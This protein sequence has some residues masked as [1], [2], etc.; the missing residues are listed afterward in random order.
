M[1][2]RDG[3]VSNSSSSSFL[4]CKKD[5]TDTQI[6]KINNHMEE[7]EKLGMYVNIH[8]EWAIHDHGDALKLSTGMDNFDMVTFLNRIGVR[9]VIEWSEF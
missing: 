4:I 3:F 8:D 1:K 5:L 7:A 2:T 6:A 9:E